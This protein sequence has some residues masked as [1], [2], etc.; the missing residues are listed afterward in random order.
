[1][2]D[3][4]SIEQLNINDINEILQIASEYDLRFV[5]DEFKHKKMVLAF[6]ETS[7]RTKLSFELAAKN[8]G[9]QVLDFM[10][11]LS[12]IQ[13]GET[14]AETLRTLEAMGVDV[15]VVRHKD[16]GTANLLSK[17]LNMS[18]INAG[19]GVNEHPSQAL[20]DALT[21]KE[22]MGDLQGFKIAICGDIM[23][24]RVA[25]S[26]I[27]LLSKFNLDI[28]LCGP[29][30]LLTNEFAHLRYYDNIDAAVEN[31]DVIMCLRIQKERMM[32]SEVP[33]IKSYFEKYAFKRTHFEKNKEIMLMHPGPVNYGI[34]IEDG[35]QTHNR[36]LISSQVKNGVLIR[37][38][39]LKKILGEFEN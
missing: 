26:N 21:L 34:E 15:A 25:R 12:S 20:L 28:A 11:Q 3:L 24:S 30:D 13:K 2:K 35:L 1:M 22:A 31:S 18:I 39:I 38:A 10:P 4:V 32:Q 9:L 37:M 23:H 27:E 17:N 36:C 5:S 33:D 14:L 19:D 16:E 6:F 29:K 7:T 8:L